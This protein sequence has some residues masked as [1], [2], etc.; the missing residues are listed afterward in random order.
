MLGRHL[1]TGLAPHLTDGGH[2]SQLLQGQD[3]AQRLQD[4]REDGVAGAG[5][6][7][8]QVGEK[9]VLSPAR[10]STKKVK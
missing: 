9:V 3:R 7:P 5:P 8:L 10:A 1:E 6:S 2:V 4:R